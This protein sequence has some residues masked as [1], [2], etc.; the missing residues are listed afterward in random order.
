V[1]D[2]PTIATWRHHPDLVRDYI[3]K[4][5]DECRRLRGWDIENSQ[6]KAAGSLLR[7][8]QE[9]SRSQYVPP[10]DWFHA[11]GRR[12]RYSGADNA[13]EDWFSLADRGQYWSMEQAAWLV[14]GLEPCS[15]TGSDS[16]LPED[17]RDWYA[18]KILEVEFLQALD[19]GGSPDSPLKLRR[20]DGELTAPNWWYVGYVRKQGLSLSPAVERF[21]WDSMAWA[22]DDLAEDFS[23]P[24][25]F[26]CDRSQQN[27]EIGPES[28]TA[29]FK[30]RKPSKGLRRIQY[31]LENPGQDITA[32]QLMQIHED[33][34]S[35]LPDE[36]IRGFLY[37]RDSVYISSWDSSQK[38]SAPEHDVQDELRQWLGEIEDKLEDIEERRVAG[39]SD[40][41]DI[42][43]EEQLRDARSFALEDLARNSGL[44]RYSTSDPARKPTN[45]A[46]KSF[47]RA[48]DT[49]RDQGA[50]GVAAHL[51]KFVSA[52]TIWIYKQPQGVVWVLR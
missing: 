23:E 5:S 34:D 22:Q 14:L 47:N 6:H 28:Y 12:L 9:M 41:E 50:L 33:L 1:T 16:E 2:H 29:V 49:L 8:V 44:S 48:L 17:L 42:A 24:W 38:D 46:L 15:T 37:K 18:L 25:L 27:W 4:I 3:A 39:L 43:E 52:R 40:E 30:L 32:V 20:S 10:D 31:V 19:P 11:C 36:V 7:I 26:R 35:P 21:Y 51:E 13:G 45:A